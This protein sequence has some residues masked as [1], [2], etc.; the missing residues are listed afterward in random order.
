VIVWVQ[1]DQ[2]ICGAQANVNAVSDWSEWSSKE[3]PYLL[4]AF[5]TG[6][7][8]ESRVTFQLFKDDYQK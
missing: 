8:I 6:Q 2:G 1:N 7:G 4:A 5:I 3:P